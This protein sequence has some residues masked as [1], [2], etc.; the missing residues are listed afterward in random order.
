MQC[1]EQ[2]N[3][4]KGILH[5]EHLFITK[6]VDVFMWALLSSSSVIMMSES[7][8][9]RMKWMQK[10][11]DDAEW[12]EYRKYCLY[13]WRRTKWIINTLMTQNEMNTENIVCI[14]QMSDVIL[15]MA[16][17]R[18]CKQ[19]NVVIYVQQSTMLCIVI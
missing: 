18:L 1:S 7:W 16:R 3:Y 4:Y 13:R 2:K 19:K 11:F 6:D 17:R 8:W 14:E 12:N 9:R 10:Y 5:T 15:W